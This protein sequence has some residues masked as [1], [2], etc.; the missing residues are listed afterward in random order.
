LQRGAVSLL[1][2]YLCTIFSAGFTVDCNGVILL[3][4]VVEFSLYGRLVIEPC[5]GQ[6][7][8]LII[9]MKVQVVLNFI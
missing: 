7:N 9:W 6:I 4:F 5:F 2:V 3:F 8:V 1:F